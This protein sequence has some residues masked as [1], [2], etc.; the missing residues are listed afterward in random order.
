MIEYT[1]EIRR[2]VLEE[3]QVIVFVHPTD[4]TLT[5]LRHSIRVTATDISG[6]T[7][8]EATEY[9][10]KEVIKLNDIFQ[11]KWSAEQQSKSAL[12]DPELKSAEGHITATVT[13]VEAIQ[14]A[15]DSNPDTPPSE[16]TI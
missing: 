1:I 8:D 4:D 2:I 7:V 15:S 6:L 14:V 16:V 13:E 11:W 10:R 5:P 9:F 12:I 3:E